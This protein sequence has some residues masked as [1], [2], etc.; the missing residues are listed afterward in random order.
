[1]RIRTVLL[2][3]V[4][5]DAGLLC[6]VDP[7]YMDGFKYYESLDKATKDK[8][9]WDPTEL[10]GD[11]GVTFSTSYGDGVYPVYG[12]YADNEFLGALVDTDGRIAERLDND[13]ILFLGG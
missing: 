12:L 11:L 6:I 9:N 7:C 2:G 3:E 4:G 1:M 10:L 8:P 13:H 5:V